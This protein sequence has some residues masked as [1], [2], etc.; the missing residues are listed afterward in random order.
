MSG[1]EN[2]IKI[3]IFNEVIAIQSCPGL[4]GPDCTVC[5]RKYDCMRRAIKSV[6]KIRHVYQKNKKRIINYLTNYYY[7][8]L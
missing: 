1:K 8:L 4:A 3:L 6:Q 5:S 7:E 2:L